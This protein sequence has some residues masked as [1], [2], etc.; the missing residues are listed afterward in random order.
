MWRARSADEAVPVA[1]AR[2]PAAV[3]RIHWRVAV[4]QTT[5]SD[6]S[7]NSEAEMML[8]LSQDGSIVRLWQLCSMRGLGID[9]LRPA[10]AAPHRQL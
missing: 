2:P 5:S 4:G 9:R 1:S 6:R 7:H 10:E 3:R 8:M